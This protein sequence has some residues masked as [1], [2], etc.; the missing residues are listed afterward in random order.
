MAFKFEK[1][2]IEVKDI[3]GEK[4]ARVQ[5]DKEAFWTGEDAPSKKEVKKVL[6]YIGK[7]NEAATTELREAAPDIFKKEG[8]AKI[9]GKAQIGD[10]SRD[11]LEVVIVKEKESRHPGTG[12]IS[13]KPQISTKLKSS[14]L[15]SKSFLYKE[16]DA[17]IEN[18]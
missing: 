10:S 6:G 4:V 17:L 7:F 3:K 11:N 2:N 1:P 12:E 8:A 9:I 15:P 16:R 14:I 18:L 13:V 5:L